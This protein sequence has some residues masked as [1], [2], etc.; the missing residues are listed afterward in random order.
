MEEIYLES[1]KTGIIYITDLPIYEYIIKNKDFL[2][3]PELFVSKQVDF[4]NNDYILRY[5]NSD[6]KNLIINNNE[7]IIAYP[8]DEINCDSIIYPGYILIEKKRLNTKEVTCHSACISK[9]GRGILFIGRSGSGKTTLMLDMCI[10]KGYS[11]IANDSTILKLKDDKLYA[12]GGTKF[13]FLRY[14]SIKRN[15]PNLLNVFDSRE[16]DANYILSKNIDTW[17]K[18]IRVLPN[19]LNIK[20]N[21]NEVEIVKAYMVHIDENQKEVYNNIDTSLVSKLYLNELL[22]EN[23]RGVK[24][25]FMDKTYRPCLYIPS[26]D[27]EKH[28]EFRKQIIDYII[29]D[30][31]LEYI[32]GN[33]NNV[34]N[35]IDNDFVLV[36]RK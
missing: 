25:T 18:K 20:T 17:R 12:N 3:F 2:E 34:A 16:V 29:N 7:M 11:L 36:K 6:D 23:I 5:N 9:D 27:T 28:Y 14:E 19:E 26:M 30:C 24:T 13:I 4:L 1:S 21:S 22:S 32:S 10:N 15:I 33:I 8:I 31:A 35:K